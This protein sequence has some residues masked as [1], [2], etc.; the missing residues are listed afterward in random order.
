MQHFLYIL[1]SKSTNTY[2][3][4]ETHNVKERIS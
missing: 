2:Y 1:H 3:T 4:G